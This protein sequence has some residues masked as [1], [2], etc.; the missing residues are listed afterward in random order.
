MSF[1][2]SATF[3]LCPCSH[4]SYRGVSVQGGL[5]PERSLSWGSLSRGLCQRTHAFENITLPQTFRMVIRERP[6]KSTR[7][8]SSRMHTIHSLNVS[9]S[10]YQGGM[11]A[12]HAPF[13]TCPPSCTPP[14]HACPF[15]A[16]HT[17][18]YACP[19][20]AMHAPPVDRQ[21]D[22]CKNITLANFVCGR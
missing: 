3:S 7:M 17:P 16:M 13:D 11:H 2:N 22:T 5:C 19:L 4:V 6:V 1:G 14:C 18:C 21:T 8:H 12:M 10:I 20:P 15:P 9:C